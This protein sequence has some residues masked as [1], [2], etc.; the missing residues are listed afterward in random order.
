MTMCKTLKIVQKYISI[1]KMNC[2]GREEIMDT[3]NGH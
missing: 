2:Q 1:T 3:M